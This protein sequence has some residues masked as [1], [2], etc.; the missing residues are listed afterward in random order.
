MSVPQNEF[1]GAQC[2]LKKYYR[3]LMKRMA[4]EIIEH[5][6]DF[7]SEN[8]GSQADEIIERYASQLHRLCTVFTN[9]DQFAFR[10]KPKGTEP[11][12]K[13]EFRC[14]GCGGVIRREDQACKLCGW[15]WK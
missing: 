8:F 3:G 15:T 4:E 9:I 14:F 10:E 13:D 6:E 7:E 1:D 12:S 11:L 5:G 2:I